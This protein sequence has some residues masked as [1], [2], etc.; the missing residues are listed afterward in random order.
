MR[1][2]RADATDGVVSKQK[3]SCW[4]VPRALTQSMA[5]SALADDSFLL[6]LTM[7]MSVQGGL[8]NPTRA[9][10]AHWM[11]SEPGAKA[12]SKEVEQWASGKEDAKTAL[13][14]ALASK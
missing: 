6:E 3:A 7:E 12:A 14:S 8:A 1:P 2:P 5:S 4:T 9:R 13:A 11:N 10:R